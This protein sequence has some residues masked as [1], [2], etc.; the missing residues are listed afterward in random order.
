MGQPVRDVQRWRRRVEAK[1]ESPVQ[2][3]LDRA[4]GHR[5]RDARLRRCGRDPAQFRGPIPARH[6]CGVNRHGALRFG[7]HPDRVQ[8]PITRSSGRRTSWATCPRAKTTSI[9]SSSSRCRCSD[10]CFRLASSFREPRI[11]YERRAHPGLEGASRLC[12]A[13]RHGDPNQEVSASRNPVS[14]PSP[15]Q[16]TY[17]SGLISTAAGA[18][19][20]PRTGRSQSPPYLALIS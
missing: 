6:R 10:S 7:H 13:S 2:G 9:R 12:H 4:P 15:T 14:G 18:A 19:T 3:E 5:T 17:P 16:A 1:R 11:T 8:A 20:W